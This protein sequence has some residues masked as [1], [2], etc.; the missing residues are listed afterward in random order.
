MDFTA[1][2]GQSGDSNMVYRLGAQWNWDTS[3]WQSSVGR[4]TGYWDAGYTHWDGDETSGQPQP[5]V[6][7]GIRPRVRRRGVQPSH[8]RPVS[9]SR[10]PI[11]IWKTT[12]W[13]RPSSSRSPAPACV[14]P[15]RRSASARCTTPTRVSNSPTTASSLHPALPHELLATRDVIKSR[16]WAQLF[17]A[18]AQR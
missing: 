8:R 9:A 2:I 13:A 16:A 15:A 3:W 17:V 1:A 4:L 14:S 11:P 5:V 7:P 12:T 10:P 18:D 6:Q